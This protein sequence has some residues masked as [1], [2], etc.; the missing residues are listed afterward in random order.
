VRTLAVRVAEIDAPERGQR[1]GGQ[2][3]RHLAS[4]CARDDAKIRPTAIDRYGRTVAHVSCR[5]VD[6]GAE[7]VRAGM[8]WVYDR[9]A[10]SSSLFT[11]EAGARHARR[12]LWSDTV[13]IAPWEWRK[14]HASR[15]FG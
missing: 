12:G 3:R 14:Q 2:A 5:G 10:T 4:L 13:P 1:F 9:Y 8:A 6:A 11:L 15:A 7:Q